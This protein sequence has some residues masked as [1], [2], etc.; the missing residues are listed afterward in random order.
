M[1]RNAAIVF[2]TLALAILV[3]SGCRQ[4]SNVI[5]QGVSNP[6]F[7]AYKGKNIE[8]ES[9]SGDYHVQIA[10][11]VDTHTAD[12]AYKINLKLDPKVAEKIN[13]QMVTYD[14]GGLSQYLD[15]DES[16]QYY[17]SFEDFAEQ[18]SDYGAITDLIPS[19]MT[20]TAREAAENVEKQMNAESGFPVFHTYR[21]ESDNN[22]Q[23][24]LPGFYVLWMQCMYEGLP[25]CV[26]P[27]DIG[28]VAQYS[29]YGVFDFSGRFSYQI[30]EKE[31]IEGVIDPEKAAEKV[32]TVIPPISQLQS[33][34]ITDISL[35]YAAEPIGKEEGHAY[36]LR[37]VWVFYGYEKGATVD[38]IKMN[39]QVAVLIY[40]DTGEYCDYEVIQGV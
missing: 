16:H 2:S 14:E 21:A 37:P 31:E 1:N 18:S 39:Y 13:P 7:T 32:S 34:E 11:K 28:A 33:L 12:S 20:E 23:E 38:N 6:S 8:M 15:P 4:K 35:E 3:I 24:D 40:A 22:K 5:E 26:V 19:G 9:Q 36:T 17:S 29:V 30:E 27:H 25:I 10:A